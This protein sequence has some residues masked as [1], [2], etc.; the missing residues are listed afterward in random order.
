MVRHVRDFA[1]AKP[2]TD[3][4]FKA[5]RAMYAYH[6]TPVNAIPESAVETT[7]YWTKQ[8]FTIDAGYQGQRLA[9]FLFLPKHV[10]QPFQTVV[11]FPSP[12]PVFAEQR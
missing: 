3:E 2:A 10:R 5:D 7:P 9:V 6:P 4:V 11:F 12:R 1:K 8:K